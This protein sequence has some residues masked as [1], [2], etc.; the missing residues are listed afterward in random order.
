MPTG[1]SGL[2]VVELPGELRDLIEGYVARRHPY[3]E[4]GASIY[5][6][7]KGGERKYLKARAEG[8]RLLRE[9]RVLEWIGGRLA[10]PEAVYYGREGST[11]FLLTTEVKD[12]PVYLL[13]REE[14]ERSIRVLAG[15][16]NF[17][18]SLDP[19]GCP[20]SYPVES[21]VEEVE[22][23]T[24]VEWLRADLPVERPVFTHGDYC[25]PNILVEGGGLGGVIDWDYGG[26][27]DPYVDFASCVDSLTYN[28]G[29]EEAER[30]W[31]P[32]FFDEYGVD[33]NMRRLDYYRR[34]NQLLD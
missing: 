15:A 13:P 28:F 32:L 7:E 24:R 9:S 20:Y 12:T 25:L 21:K 18:H 30:L 33:V 11:E 16:L 29:A 2:D 3:D 17:I 31:A 4:S 6:L 14:R 19:T 10:V 8:D 26:L 23:R 1:S 22:Q 5:V 27:A 34:L